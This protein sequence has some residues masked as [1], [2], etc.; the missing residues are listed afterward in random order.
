MKNE[1]QKLETHW[2]SEA[3]IQDEKL[4]KLEVK[5]VVVQRLT[6][7]NLSK[8]KSFMNSNQTAAEVC[9]AAG[10]GRR[11][12]FSYLP[13]KRKEKTEIMEETA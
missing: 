7:K 3:A 5:L 12:V 1:R 9:K 4:Q 2:R 11:T 6:H 8:H 10:V 13:K